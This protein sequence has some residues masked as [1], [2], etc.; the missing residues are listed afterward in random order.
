M[1]NILLENIWKSKCSISSQLH[2]ISLHQASTELTCSLQILLN[3]FFFK[4]DFTPILYNEY[5][6]IIYLIA[7]YLSF[8]KI[9]IW[10]QHMRMTSTCM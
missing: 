6:S 7:L 3:F 4:C 9:C 2:T 8:T 1:K 5:N 10:I